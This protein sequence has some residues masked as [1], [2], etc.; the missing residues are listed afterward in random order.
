MGVVVVLALLSVD[1]VSL[2][3]QR[4]A[5]SESAL[6]LSVR[7]RSSLPVGLEEVEI[8]VLYA[9]A[10]AAI[11]GADAGRLYAGGVSTLV[12]ALRFREVVA[13]PPRG[14]AALV[15]RARLPPEPAARTFVTHVIG[16]RLESVTAPLA[17]ELIG[18]D[19]AAD[20]AAVVGTLGVGGDAAAKRR[21]RARFGG[22]GELVRG[23][24]KIVLD[25][26]PA[27]PTQAETNVRV[28]ALLALGVLGGEPA[29]E[30]LDIASRSELAPFDDGFQVIR[31]ARLLGTS[32]ENAL[33]HAVAPEAK[34][35]QDVVAQAQRDLPGWPEAVVEKA[36]PSAAEPEPVAAPPEPS[37]LH[38]ALRIAAAIGVAVAAALA[39]RLR[40]RRRDTRMQP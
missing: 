17:V 40:R 31:V 39:L 16:Y 14:E 33:A 5:L 30:A 18:T 7:V 6:E 23:I 29:R 2:D 19:V 37:G 32:L 22:D 12:G 34:S 21:A 27:K 35:V 24:A 20:E 4:A 10:P 11:E 1:R 9:D 36:A 3:G 25:P 15:L 28:L 38:R 8:G 26:V 13:V